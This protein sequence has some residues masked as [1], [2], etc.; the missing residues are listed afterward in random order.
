MAQPTAYDMLQSNIKKNGAKATY[1]KI[2]NDRLSSCVAGHWLHG[3]VDVTVSSA[4]GAEMA[5]E[6]QPNGMA[7]IYA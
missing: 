2:I 3:Y 6:L 4:D 7:R 1:S 5:Y